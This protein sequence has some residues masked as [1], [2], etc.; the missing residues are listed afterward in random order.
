MHNNPVDLRIDP[1]FERILDHLD[2]FNEGKVNIYV[3][4]QEDIIIPEGLLQ[5]DEKDIL[6][7]LTTDEDFTMNVYISGHQYTISSRLYTLLEHNY[8]FNF[9]KETYRLST[10]D[11]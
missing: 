7:Y 3:I 11:I 2:K 8:N 5:F 10:D 6:R 1:V 4:Q 9:H